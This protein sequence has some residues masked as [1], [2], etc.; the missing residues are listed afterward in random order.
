MLVIRAIVVDGS[1]EEREGRT[2]RG[3]VGRRA[4][5]GCG[6]GLGEWLRAARRLSLIF[7]W[8]FLAQNDVVLVLVFFFSS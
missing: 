5:A 7:F 8:S 3:V 4:T 2:S 1:L 6:A